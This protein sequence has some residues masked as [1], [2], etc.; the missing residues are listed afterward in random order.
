MSTTTF[1]L[2]FQVQ[3][4]ISG[5]VF[6]AQSMRRFHDVFCPSVLNENVSMSERLHVQS[7]A[8]HVERLIEWAAWSHP[9]EPMCVTVTP[10]PLPRQVNRAGPRTQTPSQATPTVEE[11]VTPRQGALKRFTTRIKAL[12][13]R[14]V[15]MELEQ[16]RRQ[17]RKMEQTK[18]RENNRQFGHAHAAQAA[19][20]FYLQER[21][22]LLREAKREVED[23][24]YKEP[25]VR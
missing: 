17:K 12:C 18:I 1:T 19:Y 11:Y 14:T 10:P 23:Y 22:K 8:N 15:R 20:A 3:V 4:T 13:S 5:G 21:D 6:D 16:M 7:I 25:A 9:Q 24:G 2:Q